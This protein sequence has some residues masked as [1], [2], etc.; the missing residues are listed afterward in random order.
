MSGAI[1]MIGIPAPTRLT[2]LLFFFVLV[3]QAGCG[4]NSSHN[5]DQ[6]AD[7]EGKNP[8]VKFDAL[9]KCD[10]FGINLYQ[11]LKANSGNLCFSP[12]SLH[13]ALAMTGAGADGATE[14]EIADAIDLDLRD[15]TSHQSMGDLQRHLSE[16]AKSENL[17]IRIANRLWAADSINFNKD[18]AEVT[19]EH[20]LAE[21]ENIDFQNVETARQ[22]INEWISEQTESRIV[23]L[24][25]DGS[26][27]PNTQLVLTNTLYFNGKWRLPF[28]EKRTRSGPFY[29]NPDKSVDA[30]LMHVEGDFRYHKFADKQIIE[31]PYGDDQLSLLVLLPDTEA[32]MQKLESQLNLESLQNWISQLEKQAVNV[33][34]PKFK[35]NTKPKLVSALQSLGIVSAFDQKTADFSGMANTSSLCISGVIHQAEIE[36]SESGTEA[37]AGTAVIMNLPMAAGANPPKFRADHPF[38]FMIRDQ[39]SDAILFMGR[40]AD[41]TL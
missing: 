27:T 23:E 9:P 38:I 24:L 15:T 2:F 37:A 16:L 33:V 22:T 20:Y 34:I 17:D 21:A 6:G 26:L 41:P 4:T 19:K 30:E 31:L 14:T 8:F 28:N 39:R 18:F 13:I 36:V 10:A 7:A 1:A 25:P 3:F 12:L 40:L 32:G 5:P 29:V 11:Q 35:V